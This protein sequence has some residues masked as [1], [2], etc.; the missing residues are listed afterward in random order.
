M[1]SFIQLLFVVATNS[2]NLL[3]KYHQ[4]KQGSRLAQLAERETVNLEVVSS[5]LTLRV[6]F[7][8]RSNTTTT[9][10]K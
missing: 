7:A 8:F 2:F 4:V 9:L 6:F 10:L 1:E 5:I 3:L